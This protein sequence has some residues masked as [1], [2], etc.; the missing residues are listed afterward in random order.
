M[1]ST[2]V[3]EEPHVTGQLSLCAQLLSPRDTEPMLPKKRS[4]HNEKS[5]HHHREQ[6]LT[7][8]R[9]SPEAATNTLH[10][11]KQMGKNDA[12][13]FLWLIVLNMPEINY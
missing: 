2:L 12:V 4:Q 8:T 13:C 9:E 10:S 6:L 11:R 7:T 1:G 5:K 3:Q